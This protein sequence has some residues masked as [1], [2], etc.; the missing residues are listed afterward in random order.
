[1]KRIFKLKGQMII[2]CFLSVII[3]YLICIPFGGLIKREPGYSE[4]MKKV[5]MYNK[6]IVREL[7][8]AKLYSSNNSDIQEIFNKISDS[9]KMK[10]RPE[11]YMT[12]E[13][14]NILCSNNKTPVNNINVSGKN[15]IIE[16]NDRYYIC[17][18]IM[19]KSDSRYIVAV[20]RG[21]IG[22]D[23][24]LMVIW[25]IISMIVF[26]IITY[27]KVDYLN[28]ISE[29]VKKIAQGDL[30]TRVPIKYNN[31]I[32]SLAQNIN[33]MAKELE[34][35][36]LRQKEFITNIS[37][38]LRT[39]LTTMIG[40]LDMIEEEKYDDETELKHYINI[41]S[42][43]AS[44]LKSMMEDFFYY[45]KLSSDDIPMEITKISLNECLDMIME[46]D[47]KG[48]AEK[49]LKLTKKVCMEEVL[50]DGDP[51]LI[52]RALQNLLSNALKYSRKDT[53]VIVSLNKD[54]KQ[55]SCTISVKNVPMDELSDDDIEKMF[56]RLYKKDKSRKNGG[57]GLGLAIT[58]EIVKNHK[59]N[60]CALRCGKYLEIMINF[61][62]SLF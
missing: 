56:N 21:Y 9:Y 47:S 32:S 24:D 2:S 42:R 8:S 34:E 45:S 52:A 43:K 41:I 16:L 31:E 51:M 62:L 53:D 12:D 58:K 39:P 4:S 10:E 48:F 11:L 1:M 26:F 57:S 61:N 20:S 49:G 60:I 13:K 27:R 38:D 25:F 17:T 55:K 46:E 30:K 59:G 50:I 22:D 37:H 7:S 5:R 3:G 28:K 54:D 44:Y 40:Y 18:N 35:H 23:L 19:K 29:Y 15:E 6:D 33:Y 36:D 14:G